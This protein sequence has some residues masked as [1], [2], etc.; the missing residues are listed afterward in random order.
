MVYISCCFILLI[1]YFSIFH[2]LLVPSKMT[3]VASNRPFYRYSGHIE[4]IRFNPQYPHTN[5]PNWSLYISLRNKLREFG[6]RSK[7]FLLGD[8]FI[9]SHNHFSWYHMDIVRRKLIL[10]TIG[11]KEYYRMP[12]GHEPIS[13]VFASAFACN[14]DRLFLV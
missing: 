4:L 9:N 2:F 12:R 6:R 11:V 1:Y 7:H 3:V 5:S 8:H 14:N 13:F 10:V